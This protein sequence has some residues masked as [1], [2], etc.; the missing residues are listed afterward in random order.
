MLCASLLEAIAAPVYIAEAGWGVYG[1]VCLRAVSYSIGCLQCSSD[2][3][4][5]AAKP[6]PGLSC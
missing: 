6:V 2:K 4:G 5:K 3:G 1:R